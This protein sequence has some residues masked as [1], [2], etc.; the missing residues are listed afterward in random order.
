MSWIDQDSE[1]SRGRRQSG[2]E[3]VARHLR[4]MCCSGVLTL[5]VA[6]TAV[7]TATARSFFYFVIPFVVSCFFTCRQWVEWRRAKRWLAAAPEADA[8][9]SSGAVEGVTF[10]CSFCGKS[11]A[12]VTHLIS[13]PQ[14]T[15]VTPAH[16]CDK[17]VEVCNSILADIRSGKVKV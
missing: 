13:S 2:E 10:N 4:W 16:I 5:S 9:S 12:D 7:V 14:G 15:G 6:V 17:C 8:E 1:S 3:E 11:Q